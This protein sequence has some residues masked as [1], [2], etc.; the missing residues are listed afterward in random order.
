MRRGPIALNVHAALEPLIAIV[1]IAA[2]WIFGFSGADDAK[3]VCVAVGAVM[4]IA[5]SMTDWRLSIARVIPLRMHMMT[6]LALGGVL[7]LAP[8]V[9]GFSENGAATRFTVIAGALEILTA[10]ATRWDPVEAQESAVG[11]RQRSTPA[12]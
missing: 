4:L 11:H 3:A 1:I 2:P 5:G 10:L 8:F 6:D 7:I 12:H 9:L